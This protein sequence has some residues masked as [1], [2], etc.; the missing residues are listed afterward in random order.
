MRHGPTA[1]DI[2]R[3]ERGDYDLYQFRS[4]GLLPP[5]FTRFCDKCGAQVA[6]VRQFERFN[7]R[8]GRSGSIYLYQCTTARDWKQPHWSHYGHG[9]ISGSYLWLARSEEWIRTEDI[10]SVD[11]S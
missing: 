8:D 10:R 3:G 6:W 7:P 5:E 9:S 1:V 11:Y 2:L 4:H